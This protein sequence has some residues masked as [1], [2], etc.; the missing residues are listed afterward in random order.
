M[1][2]C[3]YTSNEISTMSRELRDYYQRMEKINKLANAM[4][5]LKRD[6]EYGLKLII[7]LASSEEVKNNE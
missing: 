2:D 5:N 6:Y 1:G 7:T 4:L 3:G